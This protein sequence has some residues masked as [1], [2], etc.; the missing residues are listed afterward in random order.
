MYSFHIDSVDDVSQENDKSGGV[1]YTS[2][3]TRHTV[4]TRPERRFY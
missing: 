4:D 2:T 1:L 3:P